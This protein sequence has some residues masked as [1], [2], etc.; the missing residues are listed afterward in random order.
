MSTDRPDTDYLDRHDQRELRQLLARIPGLCEDLLNVQTKQARTSRPGG[1]RRPK[2]LGSALPIHIGAVEAADELHNILAGWCR[3]VID[4]RGGE[5]PANATLS[6]AQW[7]ARNVESLALCEGSREALPEIRD[8]IARCIRIVDIPPEDVVVPLD[9]ERV[10]EAG[11]TIVTRQMVESFAQRMGEKINGR[12]IRYLEKAGL[13]KS[14]D[15][16][17]ETGTLFYLMG[18]VLIAHRQM[19]QRE[20]ERQAM[21]LPAVSP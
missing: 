12:R 20:L 10:K 3:I 4:Q 14:I 2:R 7:L 16:D 11:R 15:Q 6:I 18:D 5:W 13:L 8:V 21:D 9:D 17:D 1:S 19:E